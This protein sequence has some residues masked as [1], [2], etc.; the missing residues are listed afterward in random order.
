MHHVRQ[1]VPRHHAP[2]ADAERVRRLHII[3]LGNLQRLRAQ[4]AAQRRPARNAEYQAQQEQAELG[5]LDAGFKNI[6][7]LIDVDVDQ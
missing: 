7:M 3:E 4:Q 6:G 1:D 2:L 5:T